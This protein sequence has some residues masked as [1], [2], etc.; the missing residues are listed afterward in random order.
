MTL[1]MGAAAAISTLLLTGCGAS[2]VVQTAPPATPSTAL[3]SLTL[4]ETCD[5][6]PGI[7]TGT[8]TEALDQ[9]VQVRLL[10]ESGDTTSRE[11]LQPLLDA[12]AGAVTASDGMPAIQ[13]SDDILAAASDLVDVCIAAG[14]T[15]FS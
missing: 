8:G 1:K 2:E 11:A 14:S 5:Q 3:T 12:L 4:R 9:L 13:A 15:R 6:M 10:A 7:T